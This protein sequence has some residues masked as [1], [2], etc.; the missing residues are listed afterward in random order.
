MTD[1]PIVHLFC[2]AHIDPVWMWGWEEGLREALSTF[3]TAANLLDE[4]PE[5]IFN[6]N[7]SV[8]Y[9]W[10]EEYDPPLF[11]RI[12]AQ[13]MAGRWNITGGWY[14]QPDVNLPGGET[15]A[16]VI[17]EGRRYFAEKFGVRPPV[18]YNF[19]S[20]GH[21][22]GLPQ[23]L[24]ASGFSMYI[25]FRPTDAQQSLPGPFY[26]WRGRDGSEIL[27]ARP[28]TGWYCTPWPGS[29]E[30]QA[31][32]GVDAARRTG[33]DSLVTWGLGDHG[34]GPT[35]ADLLRF[36]EII[37]EF[38][39]AD[40]EVRHS[41]PE[42]F[43]ARITPYLDE[44][45]VYEGELQRTL[46]GTYT[47]VAPIKRQMREGEA[48][49]TSA[50]RWATAAWWRFGR[51]YP[52]EALREAWK[53]LMFNTFHDTLC[54]SLLESAIP[55]VNAIYGYAADVARRIIVK[56][57]HALLPDLPPTPDTVPIFVFNPHA[58][59]M[60]APVGINF[61]SSYAP[62]ETPRAFAL[63][64]DAG[65]RVIHQTRGGD[66][67]ILDEGTWQPFCG[68]IADVPPLAVRRY[69]IRFE[70]V[71]L[72][73][74]PVL[75]RDEADAI[76]IDSPFWEARFSRS[77]GLVSLRDKA[78]GR[79][80]LR[81]PVRFVAMHD[82][83][84]AWG[85][86]HRAVYSEP[87]APLE[88]LTP[89]EVGAFVGAEG[90]EGQA[91]RVIAAGPAWV[92]VEVLSGW[93]HTRAALKFTF[94]ADLT[95]IDL[96]TTLYMGAR[97]KM[98]KLQFPFDAPISR[99][100]AETPYGV[101]RYP[102]NSSEYPFARWVRLD[103]HPMTIGIANNGQHGF[104]ASADGTLNL[105][106]A[107]GGVHVSWIEGQADPN[108]SYTFMDQAQI[109]TRFRLFAGEDRAQVARALVAAAGELNQPLERFFVYAPPTP[110]DGAPS[111]PAPLLSITPETVVLGALK[112]AE[113][114]ESLVIRLYETAGE[115]TTA[116]V[117]LDGAPLLEVTLTPHQ[118]RTFKIAKGG[119][120]VACNL[121]EEA[122]QGTL[123]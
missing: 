117:Q 39:D 112:K 24:R 121:L 6:H 86:E 23:L 11:A 33:R 27:T 68:F 49:L 71:P 42:A 81:G 89:A 54:G 21:P 3:R 12:H 82:S 17:L 61:L 4:F 37:A 74:Q 118:L 59:P 87:F 107:R 60:R 120:W 111:H 55:G 29:P 36:R 98:L 116:R 34:G 97:A 78:S 64:D 14:L 85:T 35:R 119:A 7:E 101:A 103:A 80:L 110:P 19:D 104:D 18:A 16:R 84:H 1:R 108:K 15:L 51:P 31:R 57:Q 5:F 48:L 30:R 8:L 96:H 88:V 92:T 58:A 109:V 46:S 94:Y 67:V 26:R 47:S 100:T 79:E 63:Y 50:E 62:P 90:R 95:Y 2:N 20:F 22:G 56:A 106:A 40:V 32:A 28:D 73:P 105:S 123:D 25:H 70:E 122:L 9:E 115:I 75:V 102:A 41:T 69:E 44:L 114:E 77:A 65:A 52:A 72:D 43:L 91:V 13:V 113:R 83:P 53:R 99:P 10:V 76:Q 93:A 66:S 38:A 45:P